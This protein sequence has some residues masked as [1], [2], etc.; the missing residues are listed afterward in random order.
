LS[1]RIAIA[2]EFGKTIRFDTS[3][4]CVADLVE[5]GYLVPTQ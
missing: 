2:H 3:E 4:N 5:V 1:E